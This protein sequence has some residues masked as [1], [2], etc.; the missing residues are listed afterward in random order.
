MNDFQ[1]TELNSIKTR[2][3]GGGGGWSLAEFGHSMR[4]ETAIVMCIRMNAERRTRR[5]VTYEVDPRG[6]STIV[7]DREE[8]LV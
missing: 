7:G 6:V 4:G 5:T 1:H 2:N 8:A 3:S